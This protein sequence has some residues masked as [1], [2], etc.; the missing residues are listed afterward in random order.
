MGNNKHLSMKSVFSSLCIFLAL[1]ATS[2]EATA[3]ARTKIILTQDVTFKG[4]TLAQ[5]TGDLKEC[6]KAGYM[7]ANGFVNVETAQLVTGITYTTTSVA[8]TPENVK[9]TFVSTQLPTFAGTAVTV[10]STATAAEIKT[11]IEAIKTAAGNADTPF[12]QAVETPAAATDIT[13]A[14]AVKS[15]PAAAAA[16]A[17]ATANATSSASCT[18]QLSLIALSIPVV[19]MVISKM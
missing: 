1:L 5:W 7:N 6:Y 8:A 14:L 2:A 4:V 3:A 15:T 16:A 10:A 19:A 17:N 11:G 9:V 13:A 12:W 18:G